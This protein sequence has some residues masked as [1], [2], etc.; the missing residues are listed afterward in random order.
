MEEPESR[1][2]PRLLL[3][4]LLGGLATHSSRGKGSE[5]HAW[6][7][8]H[9]PGLQVELLPH[10]IGQSS[11]RGLHLTRRKPGILDCTWEEEGNIDFGGL[12]VASATQDQGWPNS[13]F[14]LGPS[15]MADCGRGADVVQEPR[16]PSTPLCSG[17]TSQGLGL[18]WG[19][20]AQVLPCCPR[21]RCSR[22]SSAWITATSGSR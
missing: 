15:R 10:S 21:C 14:V 8:F 5:E 4:G 16:F 22:K 1:C 7:S 11:G 3:P 12:L 17:H 19:E 20:G 9:G 13:G 6:E 18:A 2:C